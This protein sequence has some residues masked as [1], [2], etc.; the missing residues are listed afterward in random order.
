MMGD[1]LGETRVTHGS[2]ELGFY[3][4]TFFFCFSQFTSS[5]FLLHLGGV[6]SPQ[7][8]IP[9]RLIHDRTGIDL[10]SLV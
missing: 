3:F 8:C 10:I 1:P 6:Q 5:M 2:L 9:M 7:G 4:S